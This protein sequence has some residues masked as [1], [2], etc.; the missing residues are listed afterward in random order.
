[1]AGIG[2]Q[3]STRAGFSSETTTIDPVQTTSST[4]VLIYTVPVPQNTTYDIT[5]YMMAV[6]SDGSTRN[7]GTTRGIFLRTTGNISQEGTLTKNLTGILST[8]AVSFTPNNTNFT[9]EIYANG[10]LA[11]TINWDFELTIKNKV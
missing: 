4:P 6:K 11:T 9:V 10:L 7:V 2:S 1:M 8:A 5:V 3:K